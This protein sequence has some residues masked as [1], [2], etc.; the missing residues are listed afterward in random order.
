MDGERVS[1]LTSGKK[2]RNRDPME[3]EMMRQTLKAASDADLIFLL[4]DAKVGLTTD[5]DETVRWLRTLG[6]SNSDLNESQRTSMDEDGGAGA[7]RREWKGK[8]VVILANKLEGDAWATK[9]HPS[10]LDHLEDISLIGFG[11]AIPISFASMASR[12]ASNTS[13]MDPISALPQLIFMMA[14]HA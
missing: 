7:R 5:L 3:V 11:E 6:G 10:V 1:L 13:E 14:I 4:Y 8:E 2:V 9:L 12:I